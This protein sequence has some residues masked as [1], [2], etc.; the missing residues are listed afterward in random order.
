ELERDILAQFSGWGTVASAI[1]REVLDLVGNTDL[2]SDNAFQTPRFIIEAVWEILE[3]LGFQSGRIADPA[4][5][6]GLWAGF[7]KPEYRSNS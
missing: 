3:H 7:Q 5:N 1:N 6:I 2:N 4:A